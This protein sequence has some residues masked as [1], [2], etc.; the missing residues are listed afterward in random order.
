MNED[1]DTF[2]KLYQKTGDQKYKKWAEETRSRAETGNVDEAIKYYQEA[3]ASGEASDR[4]KKIL[5]GLKQEKKRRQRV[6]EADVAAEAPMADFTDVAAAMKQSGQF[7]EKALE[8]NLADTLVKGKQGE[9]LENLKVMVDGALHVNAEE[10]KYAKQNNETEEVERLNKER[11]K[12][13]NMKQ[14]IDKEQKQRQAKPAGGMKSATDVYQAMAE[15]DFQAGLRDTY[16]RKKKLF[17]EKIV[18]TAAPNAKQA[19]AKALSSG[20]VGAAREVIQKAIVDNNQALKYAKNDEEK[21]RLS[22]KGEKLKQMDE[23]LAKEQ[24][25]KEKLLGLDVE[26]EA[27]PK[28][29]FAEAIEKVL[30]KDFQ[31]NVV[32][33]TERVRK[34]G[35]MQTV[36]SSPDINK[37]ALQAMKPG[38]AGEEA[39]NKL[40]QQI[41]LQIE[42]EKQVSQ[43]AKQNK[44]KPTLQKSQNRIAELNTLLESVKN[45]P[46]ARGKGASSLVNSLGKLQDQK[47]LH[48]SEREMPNVEAAI[49]KALTSKKPADVDGVLNYVNKA[50]QSQTQDKEINIRAGAP[51]QEIKAIEEKINKLKGIKSSLEKEKTSRQVSEQEAQKVR[52][53]KERQEQQKVL[54]QEREK[55]L[56]SATSTSKSAGASSGQERQKKTTSG[57]SGDISSLSSQLAEIAGAL[58][59]QH[60]ELAAQTGL[61]QE[62]VGAASS[63]QTPLSKSVI[64]SAV[65]KNIG[66]INE[67]IQDLKITAPGGKGLPANQAYLLKTL[68][69]SLRGVR[70]TLRQQ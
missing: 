70:K 50:I 33:H 35:V 62:M 41:K 47:L 61:L 3:V 9:A 65:K 7:D 46:A 66:K 29:K 38:A 32:P 48:V 10:A 8:E 30:S 6:L 13:E 22:A 58:K 25:R 19:A 42:K 57:A 28:P 5:T 39:R 53:T 69:R 27:K 68:N 12:L 34:A 63:A 24:Q 43:A 31:A 2:D 21:Q 17:G 60:G 11:V 20:D 18:K 23:V 67:Q 15:D 52:V 55:E 45:G 16:D 49:H 14:I 37:L 64:E 1:A 54:R 36:K 51:S 44:D 59:E 56:R 26:V 40:Q 4:D